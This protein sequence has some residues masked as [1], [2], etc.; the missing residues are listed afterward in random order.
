MEV[1]VVP[2]DTNSTAYDDQNHSPSHVVESTS[3]D[4]K[5]DSLLQDAIENDSDDVL[6]KI[7]QTISSL[8]QIQRNNCS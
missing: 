4:N 6:L 2:N 8:P 3:N 5:T 1:D 7:H